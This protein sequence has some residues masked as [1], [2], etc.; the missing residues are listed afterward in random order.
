[1]DYKDLCEGVCG[2]CVLPK[3]DELP[4]IELY[5][6]QV[7]TLVNKYIGSASGEP[8][9]TSSMINNYVKNNIIPPPVKKKYSRSH[10]FRLIIICVLKSVLPINDIAE[11]IDLLLQNTN[12]E[13]DVLNSFG[14]QY[15]SIVRGIADRLESLSENKS[16]DSADEKTAL[17]SIVMWS[18]IV[19]CGSKFF[20]EKALFGLHSR[21]SNL[22]EKA[23]KSKKKPQKSAEDESLEEIY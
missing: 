1:M 16:C 8:A 12:S 14:E 18:A 23:K 2:N 20:A 17:P 10:L 19:S 3:W 9:L 5:M 7:I 11:M 6:D 4:D 21:E 15:N 13:E 22:P